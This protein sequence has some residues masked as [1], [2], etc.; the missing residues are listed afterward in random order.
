MWSRHAWTGVG[1]R[2]R[3]WAL[4]GVLLVAIATGCSSEPT[5]STFEA[6]SGQFSV[7]MPGEPELDTVSA[8]TAAGDIVLTIAVVEVGDSAYAA[9]EGLLPPGIPFDIYAGA[10]EAVSSSMTGSINAIT[11]VVIDGVPC[12]RFDATGQAED[13]DVVL[14]GMMCHA[15]EQFAQLIAVGTDGVP[16]DAGRFMDS[17]EFAD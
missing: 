11:D 12:V 17:L 16:E 10:E 7:E 8:P 4:G 6:S 14:D 13:Q 3:R 5:W 9:T 1:N 2:R 15:N